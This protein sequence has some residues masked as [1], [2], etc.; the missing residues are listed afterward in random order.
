MSRRIPILLYHRV[1]H[2]DGSFMDKYTVSPETFVEQMDWIRRHGWQPVT[3]ENAVGSRVTANSPRSLALTFDDGF[4]SNRDHAWPV[5]EK[6]RFPSATFVVT[7]CL[8][9]VNTW[10]GPSRSTYPLL[11]AEDLAGADPRLMTFHSH[12]ATHADL[13]FLTHDPASLRHEL[14][15]PR[16]CLA[17]LPMA[18]NLFAYPRGSWNW[19]VMEHVRSAGYV[20]ACTSLEGLNSARTNPFLLRRIEIEERDVGWRLGLKIR[21]GRDLAKWPPNRPAEVAVFAAWIRRDRRPIK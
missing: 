11:S 5:L 8:G 15:D 7:D 3:L 12:S 13:T 18:G 2:R 17:D 21:S 14:E 6:Y 1:G 10:D 20:G 4:A 16:R 9:N 19:A